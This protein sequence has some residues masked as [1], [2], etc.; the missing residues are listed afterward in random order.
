M[1]TDNY[2]EKRIESPEPERLTTPPSRVQL[3]ALMSE[4]EESSPHTQSIRFILGGA[5]RYLL[6]V[7]YLNRMEGSPTWVLSSESAGNEPGDVFWSIE[8]ENPE[9]IYNLILKRARAVS[10]NQANEKKDIK[11][12]ERPKPTHIEKEE[13]SALFLNRYKAI[14]EVGAGGMSRVFKAEDTKD[15][16]L[17]AVK[18]LHPHLLHE[19]HSK[20]STKRF[21]QEFKATMALGHDNIVRVHDYG[22]TSDGI[23]VMV[24]EYLDGHSLEQLLRADSRLRL[25]QFLTTFY[26]TCSA[27]HHAH[28]RGVIHRDVKPSNIM[29][30]KNEQN[31]KIVKL[32]DFGIAK[33]LREED[34][35]D[36]SNQK[37]TNTGDVFGSPYYMSPEQCKGETLDARSDIYSLGCVMYQSLMGKRPF[38]GENAYKTIYMHVNVKPTPFA[39]LRVDISLP[40]ALEAV[41]MKCLEKMPSKRYQTVMELSLDLQRLAQQANQEQ[42]EN[43]PWRTRQ[44]QSGTFY[45]ISPS[46]GKEA[47]A[48][49]GAVLKLLHKAGLVGESDYNKAMAL[50]GPQ[51]E[52]EAGKYLVS[53]NILDNKTLHAAVQVQALIEK[54]A[55][56]TEKAIIALHYCQRSRIG[57]DEALDELGWKIGV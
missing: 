3:A 26:Q 41:V 11:T 15:G 42:K 2:S 13:K 30:V 4:A 35:D 43:Q 19:G 7:T 34:D 27:L 6:T 8:T 12:I 31:V 36:D 23:P 49:V 53:N 40:P 14:C 38:E 25:S 20:R 56:K 37:L 24:M 29:M 28:S 48:N 22:F 16:K 47:P 57:L 52:G 45:A 46:T 54:Q 10:A 33:V 50:Q 51:A 44:T 32:L 9:Q 5:S 39:D 21:E 1:T 18:V 55:L 17:V